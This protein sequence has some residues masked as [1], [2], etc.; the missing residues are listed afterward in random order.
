[1]IIS[2]RFSAIL[3]AMNMHNTRVLF[4]GE[5]STLNISHKNKIVIISSVLIHTCFQGEPLSA[6]LD[7]VCGFLDE[8]S[9]KTLIDELAKFRKADALV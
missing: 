9:H 2:I 3:S 1:M 4:T 5:Y 7:A 6:H 8:K